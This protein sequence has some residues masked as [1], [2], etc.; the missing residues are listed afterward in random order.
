[1]SD[2]TSSDHTEEEDFTEESPSG[3]NSEAPA[4]TFIEGL[5]HSLADHKGAPTVGGALFR[6]VAERLHAARKADAASA[7]EDDQEDVGR[8]ARVLGDHRQRLQDRR[9]DMRGRAAS[10]RPGHVQTLEREVVDLPLVKIDCNGPVE[11]TRSSIDEDHLH[12]L[13]ATMDEH[14]LHEPI[15]VVES[16]LREGRY[17]VVAGFTRFMAAGRLGW[18]SI[19]CTVLP[20]DTP[21]ELLFIIHVTENAARAELHPADMAAAAIK[22]RDR[23]GIGLEDF[24]EK[25]GISI[26]KLK[27]TV[28]ALETLPQDIVEDWRASTADGRGPTLNRAL[29]FRLKHV[30]HDVASEI[31]AQ[32]KASHDRML[33]AVASGERPLRYRQPTDR[34]PGPRILDCLSVALRRSRREQYSFDEVCSIVDFARGIVR[35]IPGLFTPPRSHVPRRRSA[36]R[37]ELELQGEAFAIGGER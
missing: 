28:E 20:A 2:E 22:A 8:A 31:W 14:G 27:W 23:F 5:A 26:S 17:H 32:K 19:R 10:R 15:V 16:R 35:Q 29:F 33:F 1:M 24:A 36:A 6:M 18:P 34:R 11:N 21:V 30:P 13:S 9:S 12:G 3:D 4:P 25:V 37:D 7:Q